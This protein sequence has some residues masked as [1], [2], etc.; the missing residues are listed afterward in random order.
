MTATSGGGGAAGDGARAGVATAS[1]RLACAFALCASADRPLGVPPVSGGGVTAIDRPCGRRAP[2]RG[3]HRPRPRDRRRAVRALLWVRNSWSRIHGQDSRARRFHS[4]CIQSMRGKESV[5]HLSQ[6]GA[7]HEHSGTAGAG[8]DGVRRG[9]RR[10]RSCGPRRRDPI[11]AARAGKIRG[12]GGEGLRSRR[13][14]SLGSGDRS[15]RPRWP[16]SRMAQRRIP[17]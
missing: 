4:C 14:H 10:R 5:K 7:S 17:S 2:R 6:D 13:P 16:P 3:A 8:D 12:C 11:E 15:G 9:H 1:T